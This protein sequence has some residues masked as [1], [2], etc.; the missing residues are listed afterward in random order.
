MSTPPPPPAPRAPHHRRAR[1][2]WSASQRVPNMGHWNFFDFDPAL[3]SVQSVPLKP[4]GCP[5]RAD[6][7]L[8]AWRAPRG[9]AGEAEQSWHALGRLEG[10]LRADTEVSHVANCSEPLLAWPRRCF[11]HSSRWCAARSRGHLLLCAPP[12]HSVPFFHLDTLQGILTAAVDGG[13]GTNRLLM[14][15][16]RPR[17]PYRCAAAELYEL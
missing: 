8:D 2:V 11:R 10:N 6:P 12:P 7:E 1:Q 5:P 13:R 9:R 3:D 15:R 4:L 14:T 16:T 17:S